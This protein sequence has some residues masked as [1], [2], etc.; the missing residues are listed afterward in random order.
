MCKYLLLQPILAFWRGQPSPATA[1]Y[2]LRTVPAPTMPA[3][4]EFTRFPLTNLY[5]L[6]RDCMN[7][8]AGSIEYPPGLTPGRRRATNLPVCSRYRGDL[9]AC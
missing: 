7:L 9:V 5:G 6:P 4:P 8:D 3:D 2:V 1:T